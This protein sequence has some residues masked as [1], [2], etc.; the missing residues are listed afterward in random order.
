M[1]TSQR[2]GFIGFATALALLSGS[3]SVSAQTQ[4]RGE[5]TPRTTERRVER[6][7][8]TIV[9]TYS[10]DERFSRTVADNCTYTGRLTGRV[11]Q[12][13]VQPGSRRVYY[14]PDLTL[15]AEVQCPGEA[16]Q[17]L[18]PQVI[19][20]PRLTRGELE[21]FVEARG[22]MVLSHAG[23]ICTV[24]PEFEFEANRLVAGESVNESCELARGGGPVMTE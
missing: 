8:E 19:S 10:I 7:R 23:R 1:T 9:H 21:E 4:Q 13:A 12:V 15:T 17:R 20:A 11:H 24:T 18:E 5:V 16:P 14:R 22:R 6:G 3:F 2:F